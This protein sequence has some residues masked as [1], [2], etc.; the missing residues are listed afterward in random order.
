[1]RNSLLL[2]VGAL[3][4]SALVPGTVHAAPPAGSAVLAAAPRCAASVEAAARGILGGTGSTAS[5]ADVPTGFRVQDITID[6][7]LRKAY[8]RVA[9]CHDA[10]KPLTMV[11]L[12]AS[13]AGAQSAPTPAAFTSADVPAA[14]GT[15][16]ARSGNEGAPSAPPGPA[17]IARGDAVDIF[18]SSSSMRMTLHGRAA[19]SAAAGAALD[20]AL[21]AEPGS[22]APAHH[23]RGIATAAHRVEV[24]R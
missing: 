3:V 17:L 7:I 2:G 12:E 14:A 13:L 15:S 21:D 5:S 4:L 20:V 1:M 23:L 8:V 10:R 9:D 22:T 11:P 6:P 24:Q 18:V 16:S 19:E